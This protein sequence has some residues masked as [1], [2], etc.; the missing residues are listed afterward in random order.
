MTS[1]TKIRADRKQLECLQTTAGSSTLK[2]KELAGK[3]LPRNVGLPAAPRLTE[4]LQDG[5]SLVLLDT[6]WHHVQDV[7]HYSCSQLQVKVRL[8]ALLGHLQSTHR[9]SQMLPNCPYH[10]QSRR[11]NTVI[12]KHLPACARRI[13]ED[14]NAAVAHR[15]GNSLALPALKLASQQVA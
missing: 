11:H 6:L 5:A 12:L 2:H 7:M 13:S 4:M 15:L 9:L 8:N 10:Q 3:Y 1:S 14:G